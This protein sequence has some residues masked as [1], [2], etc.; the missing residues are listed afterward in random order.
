[1]C[2][3]RRIL[4]IYTSIVQHFL[5]FVK[6]RRPKTCDLWIPKSANIGNEVSKVAGR[7]GSHPKLAENP[8]VPHPGLEPVMMSLRPPRPPPY[9]QGFRKPSGGLPFEIR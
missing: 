7:T 8:R 5:Q 9:N 3:S 6:V 1:M 4:G 2:R